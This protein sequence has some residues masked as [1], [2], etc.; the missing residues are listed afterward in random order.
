MSLYG[1]SESPKRIQPDETILVWG[2]N[3]AVNVEGCISELASPWLLPR[4]TLFYNPHYLQLKQ[5]NQ[6]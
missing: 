6:H 4:G 2:K 5:I 1:M 3:A